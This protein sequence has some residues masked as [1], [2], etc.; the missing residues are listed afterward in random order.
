MQKEITISVSP[1]AA[2][3]ENSIKFSAARKLKIDVSQISDIVL[4]KRSIDARS[5]KINI[6]L[7]VTVFTK[8]QK[9]E[10]KTHQRD[11]QNVSTATP[12]VIVGSTGAFTVTVTRLEVEL[13]PSAEVTIT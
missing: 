7:N 10:N 1:K 8:G 6:H 5:Q 11:Y 9:A 13:Q 3:D 4:Q 12:V 2:S